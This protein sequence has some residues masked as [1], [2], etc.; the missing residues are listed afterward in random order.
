MFKIIFVLI[1]TF[2]GAGFASG[3]EVFNFFTIYS[4]NG[5][6]SIFIFSFL[7][8]LLIN[9]CLTIKTKLQ[10]NS[11]NEFIL[12]LEKKYKFF[13]HRFFLFI[14]NIFLASSFYIMIAALSSLFDYQFNIAKFFTITWSIFIC[15]FIFYKKN[16]KFIYIINSILMPILILFITSLCLF[17]TNLNNINLTEIN[18]SSNIFT[19]IFMGLLYLSYNSLLLIPIIFDLKINEKNNN[20]ILSLIF[21]LIILL[22]T[23]LI[24]LLL[25]SFYNLIYNLELPILFISNSSIKIFS[26][27]YFFIILSAI[28]TTMISSGYSF[29]SNFNKNNFK[30]KLIIFLLFAF[31]FCIFSFSTLINFFYPLF[32]LIGLAQIF[33]ILFDKYWKISIKLI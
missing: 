7:L 16:I 31:I 26:Y 3:K 6:I 1:G 18:N 12:Y 30:I 11:Y 27:L 33:L 28:F 15:F 5:I 9:K 20:F 17:N 25:L 21:S 19:A 2:V 22:L 10:I 32:G 23:F 29:V 24:N 4:F 8:F 14:I 13:N